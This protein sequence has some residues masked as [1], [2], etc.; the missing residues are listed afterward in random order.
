LRFSEKELEALGDF[1]S[2]KE[3]EDGPATLLDYAGYTA[4]PDQLFGYAAVFF[5]EVLE[6]D[7]HHYFA[8]VFDEKVYSQLKAQFPDGRDIQRVMNALP[9]S[10]LLQN[11]DID[12]GAAAACA[13]LVASAWNEVHIRRGVTA[14]VHG[15][16]LADLAV[17]L[18]N[19]HE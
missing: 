8:D 12:D 13:Q 17:T 10:K 4:T 14:E 1:Q 3:G 2:W 11:A 7:A 16:T 5:R 15:T 9:M 18:V 6:V 19:L